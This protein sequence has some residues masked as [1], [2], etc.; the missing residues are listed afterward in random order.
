M[1][2]RCRLLEE[3]NELLT[4]QKEEAAQELLDVKKTAAAQKAVLEAGGRNAKAV[5]ALMELDEMEFDEKTGLAGID[6]ALAQVK[7]EAPYLFVERKE[8]T[9]GTG[10]AA[11]QQKKKESEIARQFKSGLRR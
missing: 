7:A 3:K 10:F 8:K 6:K 9:V 11:S 2:E 1:E 4:A 5:L